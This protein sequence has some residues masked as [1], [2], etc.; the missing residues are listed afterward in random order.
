MFN[1]VKQKIYALEVVIDALLSVLHKKGL[2][3]RQDIQ[4]EILRS[5]LEAEDKEQL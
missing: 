2:V 3:T 5:E 4:I 1:K